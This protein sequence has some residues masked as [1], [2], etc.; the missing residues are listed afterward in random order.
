MTKTRL[1]NIVINKIT[2]HSDALDE[3]EIREIGKAIVNSVWEEAPDLIDDE[4]SS[5]QFDDEEDE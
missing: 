4:D 1:Y 2:D 3:E 5:V